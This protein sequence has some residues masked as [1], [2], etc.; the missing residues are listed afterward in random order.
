MADSSFAHALSVWKGPSP[1]RSLPP[2]RPLELNPHTHSLAAINLQDLQRTMDAQGLEIVDG[3]KE[4]LVGRK[5]L[6][7]RTRGPSPSR[8]DSL[9]TRQEASLLRTAGW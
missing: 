3:S 5:T 4:N 7:E 1:S 2:R 6:A 9:V 8:L